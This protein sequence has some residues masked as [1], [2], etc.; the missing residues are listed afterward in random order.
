MPTSASTIGDLLTSIHRMI[1][2]D[3]RQDS[4]IPPHAHRALRV[5]SRE[6]IRPAR[7]A[8]HLRVTPRAVTSVLDSL[9]DEGLIS[10]TPDPTDRRAKV[11]AITTA[12]RTALDAANEIRNAATEHYLARLTESEKD[13]LAAL[14]TKLTTDPSQATGDTTIA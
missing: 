14:L 13:E 1:R 7:L 2:H 12:G 4:L 10:I 11:A 9:V 6:P 3:V 5:I 8:E